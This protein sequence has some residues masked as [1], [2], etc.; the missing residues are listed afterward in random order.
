[1]A[2]ANGRVLH[3]PH[4]YTLDTLLAPYPDEPL[5]NLKAFGDLSKVG[6][7]DQIAGLIDMFESQETCNTVMKHHGHEGLAFAL[8]GIAQAASDH[9]V[10]MRKRVASVAGFYGL[11]VH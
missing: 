5:P 4:G 1:V 7:R 2:D 10:H 6:D 3:I 8:K 11:P 9:K